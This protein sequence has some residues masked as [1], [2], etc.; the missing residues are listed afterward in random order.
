MTVAFKWRGVWD[1]GAGGPVEFFGEPD[2][3]PARDLTAE[4]V[5]GLNPAQR[6]KLESE[7]GKRL[8]RAVKPPE[9]KTAPKPKRARTRKAASGE[10]DGSA[11]VAGQ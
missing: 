11:P 5:A 3:L 10:P 9:P 2:G 8:Y 1:E 6:E 7:A 4:E